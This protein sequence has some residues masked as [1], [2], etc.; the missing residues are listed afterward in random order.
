MKSSFRLEM[1][2]DWTILINEAIS[3]Q[4]N[5]YSPY[6]D[7][8][9]GAAIITKEGKIFTGCNVENA[10]YGLTVCAER[11][12]VFKAISE[13]YLDL[14]AIAIVASDSKP[15]FPCGACRQV[16]IEFNE[17]MKVYVNNGKKTY[18]I[19]DLLPNSFSKDQIESNTNF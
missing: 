11:I 12:A 10:S 17:N 5:A 7:F 19:S 4:K 2:D 16:L 18:T 13:G 15:T 3:A 8:K 14:E 6:S 1:T 9:V